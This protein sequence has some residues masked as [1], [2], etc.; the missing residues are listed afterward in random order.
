MK[1]KINLNSI[2]L[3]LKIKNESKMDQILNQIKRR[4]FNKE[5]RASNGKS[6]RD[7]VKCSI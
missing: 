4:K 7:M 3:N 1:R 5:K 2:Y 6:I